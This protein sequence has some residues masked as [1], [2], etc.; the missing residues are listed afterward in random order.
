MRD[1]DWGGKWAKEKCE[2]D[3]KKISKHVA[4]FRSFHFVRK[5]TAGLEETTQFEAGLLSLDYVLRCLPR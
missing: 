2:N 4:Y 5:R 3:E 1:V